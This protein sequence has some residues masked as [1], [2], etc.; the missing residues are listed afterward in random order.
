IAAWIVGQRRHAPECFIVT[1]PSGAVRI[2]EAARRGGLDISGTLFYVDSEPLTE[3]KQAEITAAGGRAFPDYC[4]DDTG[5]LGLPCEAPAGADD[6]HV[7]IDRVAIIP[8]RRM[9]PGTDTPVDAFLVTTLLPT[10]PRFFLNVELDDY[11]LLDQRACG[12]GL[13]QLG[14]TQHVS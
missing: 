10:S 9:H 13:A 3:A 14:L 7:C 8:R 11:G 12:C 6:M 5:S 4:A 1:T 2:C